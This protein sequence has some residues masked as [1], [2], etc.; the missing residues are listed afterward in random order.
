[1]VEK[2]QENLAIR[3]SSDPILL[4]KVFIKLKDPQYSI[5]K[6]MEEQ[7]KK[8]G[9]I[10]SVSKGV[11]VSKVTTPDDYQTQLKLLSGVQHLLDRVHDI[12]T[13]LYGIQFRYKELYN[14]ALGV[15]MRGYFDEINELKEGVRKTVIAVALQPIQEGI[16]RLQHLIDLS[17][18]SYKH[19]T[20]TNWNVKESTE[21]IKD[22]LSMYRFGSNVRVPQDA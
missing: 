12:T 17:E 9:D 1:M 8:L 16:D 6:D 10:K 14:E 20:A 18:S 13:D 3:V 7:I 2:K 5:P 15:V 22:F 4:K 11:L 21:I 19:L